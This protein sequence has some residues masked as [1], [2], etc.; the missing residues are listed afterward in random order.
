MLFDVYGDGSEPP[1]VS[2]PQGEDDAFLALPRSGSVGGIHELFGNNTIGPDG[3][4]ADNGFEAL[5]KYD[6]HGATG[7]DGKATGDG[8]ISASDPIFRELRLWQD[9][10]RDGKSTAGELRSLDDAG[11]DLID[12]NYESMQAK[13][14]FQNE[15]RQ[16]S[17]FRKRGGSLGL[18]FDLWFRPLSGEL[19]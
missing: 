1:R 11:I 15:T 2:W 16:R 18:I 13:D 5:R 7:A 9:S 17:V 4:R 19:E 3:R 12:L 8:V 6:T 10:N 14:E